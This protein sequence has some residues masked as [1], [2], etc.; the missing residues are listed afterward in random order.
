MIDVATTREAIRTPDP[1]LFED[2]GHLSLAVTRFGD[3]LDALVDS[4]R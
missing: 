1:H 2:E 4:G 3:I